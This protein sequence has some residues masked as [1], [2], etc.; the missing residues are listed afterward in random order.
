MRLASRTPTVTADP[1][2]L[3][4]LADHLRVEEAEAASAMAY[5]AAAAMEL[6]HYA[7][8]A[9]LAQTI[10]AEASAEEAATLSLPLPIGPLLSAPTVELINADGSTT[11]IATATTTAGL[12]PVVTLAD[13]PGGPVRVTYSAGYGEDAAAI[14]ADLAHAIL[15]HAL[16][17]Y[18]RRGDVDRFAG[19][20]PSAARIC[21]R[22][23]RVGIG[24]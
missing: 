14:P 6:E 12:H 24:A 22:Y 16:R 4:A 11:E 15:D 13:D 7:A 5:V 18:D 8:L 23:R 10:V 2:T 1:V 19:L 3:T 20:A 17:L 9:L 21:A